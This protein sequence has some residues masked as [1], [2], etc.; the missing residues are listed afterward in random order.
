MDLETPVRPIAAPLGQPIEVLIKE[1]RQ[2]QHH[3]WLTVGAVLVLVLAGALVYLGI[4]TA[5]GSHRQPL[6][7]RSTPRAVAAGR[8]AGTWHVKYY[9]VRIGV[10]GQK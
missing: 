10:D 3:R 9:Y 8:F 1:A 7:T 4:S 2:R 6:R 5:G